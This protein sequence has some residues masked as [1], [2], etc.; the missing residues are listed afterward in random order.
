MIDRRQMNALLAL[1][2]ATGPAAAQPGDPAQVPPLSSA[3]PGD[4]VAPGWRHQTLP[5]VER[6]NRYAIVADDGRSVLRVSSSSS[7]SSWVCGLDIDPARTPFLH[8]RWKVSRSLPGSDVRIKGGDDY[9]ARLY[10]FFDLPLDRLTLADRLRMQ[11]ARALSSADIPAASLCYVWGR[12]Q[13]AGATAW[14]PYTDRVRMV[15]LDSGDAQAGTWRSHV[16][17]V[18]R[19]WAEAFDGPVP[20]ISGIG[21]G[22]DTD[23]TASEVETWFDDPRFD[24]SA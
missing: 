1:G 18:R 3:P 13:A 11:A 12:A 24:A 19:D 21:V 9:A 4:K 17:D 23:N 22:A 15:V 10:V 6:A 7:A 8:W 16:R 20:R 5:K 14:N 2:L